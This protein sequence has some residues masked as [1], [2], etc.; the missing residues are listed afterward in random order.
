MSSKA[1]KNAVYIIFV[2]YIAVMLYLLFF[3]RMPLYMAVPYDEYIQRY[4]NFTPFETL[5]R[6]TRLLTEYGPYLT[7]IAIINL[8]GN[9]LLFIPLGIFLPVIWIKQQKIWIFLQTVVLAV[10]SV[11][12]LQLAARLG[13]CDVDDLILNLTGALIGFILWKTVRRKNKEE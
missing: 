12:A 6:F 2:I 3:R 1:G 8:A 10:S 5:R 11:E 4:T 9:V 7:K 13:S